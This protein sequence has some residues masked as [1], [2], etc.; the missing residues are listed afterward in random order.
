MMPVSLFDKIDAWSRKRPRLDHDLNSVAE[1]YVPKQGFQMESLPHFAG[2]SGRFA[3]QQPC[4]RE[5]PPLVDAS[6]A[7]Q[8]QLPCFWSVFGR[9]VS[10]FP[11]F[12]RGHKG[13][14]LSQLFP[15][16]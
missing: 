2:T 15:C 14:P 1:R 4:A 10:Q 8:L 3:R 5:K 7:F 9:Y 13:L 16:Y 11:T 12:G 6:A